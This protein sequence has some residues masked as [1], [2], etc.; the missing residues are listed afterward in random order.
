MQVPLHTLKPPVSSLFL[1]T[2]PAALLKC[3]RPPRGHQDLPSQRSMHLKLFVLCYQKYSYFHPSEIS[4]FSLSTP[5]SPSQFAIITVWVQLT[6]KNEAALSSHE[7][8]AE[9]SDKAKLESSIV[10][11]R[12]HWEDSCLSCLE[13]LSCLYRL[14]KFNFWMLQ[15]NMIRSFIRFQWQLYMT[16]FDLKLVPCSSLPQKTSFSG[17]GVF[18]I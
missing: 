18:Q 7:I 17:R 4:Q 14:F 6:N 3:F 13:L 11:E 10:S 16:W 9:R 1:L 15:E 12:P 8:L 2:S 5:L